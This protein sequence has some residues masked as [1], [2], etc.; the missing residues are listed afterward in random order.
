[1]AA[2][3]GVM[4]PRAVMPAAMQTLG[5][6]TPHAWALTGYQSVLVG[7]AGLSGILGPVAAL[8]GFAALFF[9]IALFR[10]RREGPL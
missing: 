7:G 10:L 8:A 5:L 1:M 3:G 6:A 2:L 9:G 4:V